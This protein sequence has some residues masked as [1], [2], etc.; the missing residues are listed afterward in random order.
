KILTRVFFGVLMVL[1]FLFVMFAGHVYLCALVALVEVL[2]FKE[3]VK[4]R[5][6]AH[7]ETIEKNVPLFRTTQWA[8]FLVS[9]YYTYGDFLLELLKNNERTHATAIYWKSS[10][11]HALSSFGLYSAV[12]V[13]TV[14]TLRKDFIKFQLNQLCW[15]VCVLIL[16]VGQLKYIMHNIMNGLF[17][18]VYPI[19]LVVINDVMA[20][21]CGMSFGKKF[22]PGVFLKLSP[23]KTWEGFIGGGIFTLI[24]GWYLAGYLAKFTWMTCP[25]DTL[26]IWSP[27]L[28]CDVDSNFVGG[29]LVFPEQIFD[30]IPN[31]LVRGLPNVLVTKVLPIQLHAIALAIFASLV[32]P[33]GGFLAS[34]IKRAYGIKDFDSIIPG[35]GGIM[36]RMDCQFLM[37][38]CTWVHYNVFVKM[39]TISVTKLL[40]LFKVLPADE[41]RDFI[42]RASE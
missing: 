38:L 32:A 18:F 1:G 3:L 36:D 24:F 30:L 39:G 23:N 17:W 14:V 7:L 29:N 40:F 42:E 13:I 33:F 16:T 27:V 31:Q 6:N 41:Q 9:I 26:S 4:V 34:G 10:Q 37:A 11:F 35:H 2:L 20:Y 12:F 21:V 25:V 22:F 19:L 28:D 15:T 8:W 5:Y